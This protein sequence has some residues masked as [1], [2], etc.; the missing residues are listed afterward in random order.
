VRA[1]TRA[2]ETGLGTAAEFRS[3][4][5]R[6]AAARRDL[7]QARYEYLNQRSQLLVVSGWPPG[8]VVDDMARVLSV[9]AM[10]KE[11]QP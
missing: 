2:Q 10:M 8:T 1:A 9:D 4:L 5:A 3:A 11:T 7:I 6:Q